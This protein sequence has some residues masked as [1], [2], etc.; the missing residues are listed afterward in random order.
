MKDELFNEVEYCPQC[1]S[2][3]G[4]Y[5][6][7]QVP[8]IVEQSLDGTFCYHNDGK[9]RKMSNKEMLHHAWATVLSGEYEM[10]NCCC[11][12]CGWIGEP[13]IP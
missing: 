9:K 5:Y 11:S 7:L 3:K 10:A 6:T 4:L 12:L 13:H 8:F 1:G 2:D